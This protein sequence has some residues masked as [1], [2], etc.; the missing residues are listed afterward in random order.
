MRG[1]DTAAIAGL[2]AVGPLVSGRLAGAA[3][4]LRPLAGPTLESWA[5]AAF[6]GT[7]LWW[8]PYGWAHYL[9]AT[10]RCAPLAAL[11]PS[12][13]FLAL[14]WYR[15][16]LACLVPPRR[17]QTLG[18]TG[19]V[20]GLMTLV[21]LPT[22]LYDCSPVCNDA[23]TYLGLA[24]WLQHHS[25]GNAATLSASEPLGAY[26]YD[27]HSRGVH[28]GASFFHA[29]VTALVPGRGPIDTYLPVLAWG[30]ALNVLG[31]FLLARWAGRQPL[32]V[33]LATAVLVGVMFNPLH[34]SVSWGFF[35]QMFGTAALAASLAVAARIAGRPRR[36]RVADALTLALCAAAVL[37]AYSELA[38][39]L[40]AALAAL[41]LRL[42]WC[43]ARDGST[44]RLVVFLT[45]LAAGLLL[46]GNIELVRIPR[47]A[48]GLLA[49][50]GVG[51]EQHWDA[52]HF[53]AFGMGTFAT[54]L[55]CPAQQFSRIATVAATTLLVLGLA[56]L[57]RRGTAVPLVAALA[58]FALLACHYGLM[59]SDP[60]TGQRG[61]SWNLFK[62]AK[63]GFPLVAAVQGVGLGAVAR[64]L[65]LR[66]AALPGL[67]AGVACVAVPFHVEMARTW[68]GIL[69]TVTSS[70][71]PLHELR[72]LTSVLAAQ[73]PGLLFEVALPGPCEDIWMQRLAL[74][75]YG[76]RPSLANFPR[77]L[78]T[79]SGPPIEAC[80]LPPARDTLCLT[81]LP[82]LPGGNC[83][84]LPCAYKILPADQPV[85][86]TLTDVQQL[87]V[88]PD[89]GA[90]F[91]LGRGP[92]SVWIWSS[93]PCRAQ[94]RALSSPSSPGQAPEEPCLCM[95]TCAEEM[96]P[97]SPIEDG[98]LVIPLRLAG[99]LT[100]I[101]LSIKEPDG[102]HPAG[103]VWDPVPLTQL[104]LATE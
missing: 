4:R 27:F 8:L 18:L 95:A 6:A 17:W 14:A 49:T 47:L 86:I 87:G 104:K 52:W 2:C 48:R 45:L 54:F 73:K 85:I 89:G 94:L 39:A 9:G 58:A 10:G 57:A 81:H 25:F 20:A 65:P 101:V 46:L 66:G 51:C 62:L 91:G 80:P 84:R 75:A 99:G 19:V 79:F 42:G 50:N 53:W 35:H 16:R 82:V 13:G 36:L 77:I 76:S 28:M 68:S 21:L 88:G 11:L 83:R 31:I 69:R 32:A 60:W 38:P 34:S 22:F 70:S 44:T 26:A 3:L 23:C 93:R 29:L 64:R 72:E 30:T 33:A 41:T 7:A 1:L 61:H 100:R 98:R 97:V 15:G 96:L 24:E 90:S 102:L 55:L 74:V 12:V 103:T 56:R 63:Y 37:S 40:L 78:G 71:R 59:A 43:A 92:A 67:C 5:L